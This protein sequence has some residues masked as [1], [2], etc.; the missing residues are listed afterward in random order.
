MLSWSL[1]VLARAGCSP[2]VTVA[3]PDLLDRANASAAGWSCSVVVAGGS[4]RQTSVAAGLARVETARVVVHDAARPFATEADV[5]AVLDALER[6]PGAIVASPVDDTLKRV[7][8]CRIVETVPR[9]GLWRA[10]TP[11]AFRTDV[12]REAHRRALEEGFEATDD[13]ALLERYGAEVVVVEAQGPNLKL[14][15]PD[16]FPVAE[17]L[18]KAER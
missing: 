1:D 14:T 16:D 13:S 5:R 4:S 9:R 6:A 12:L 7:Q 2:V 18:L 10:Q 17:A 11:Q 3:P 15:R 8:D